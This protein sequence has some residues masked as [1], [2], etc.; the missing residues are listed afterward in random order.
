MKVRSARHFVINLVSIRGEVAVALIPWGRV[1]V[2]IVPLPN[3]NIKEFE[4]PTVCFF[5]SANFFRKHPLPRVNGVDVPDC[6]ES[7]YTS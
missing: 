2:A 1:S 5:T 6:R 7:S 4:V 3:K